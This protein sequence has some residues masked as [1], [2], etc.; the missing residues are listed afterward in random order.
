MQKHAAPV[1]VGTSL[2]HGKR[3]P[4]GIGYSMTQISDTCTR[5]VGRAYVG[6]V[7][8]AGKVQGGAITKNNCIGLVFDVNP[9]L[10]N[11]RVAVI[12]STFSKYVY[13]GMKFTYV[14]QCSTATSGSVALVFERDPLAIAANTQGTQFLSEV[15]SYEHAVLSPAY[16]QCSTAY[17]RDSK[18]LKTWFLGS[19]DATSSTRETS[20]G[21]LLVYASNVDEASSGLGF[22]V[23]DYVLDLVAPNLLPN[24]QNVTQI[25]AAP[26]QWRDLSIDAVRANTGMSGV[27]AKIMFDGVSPA[28][29]AEWLFPTTSL[30]NA[31]IFD[32]KH[33]VPGTVGEII[34]AGAPLP[35]DTSTVFACTPSNSGATAQYPWYSAKGDKVFLKQG[36][37]LYFV[38]HS[39][40]TD[41]AVNDNT[42]TYMSFHTTLNSAKGAAS[43]AMIPLPA[44]PTALL[45]PDALYSKANSYLALNGWSRL[46]CEGAGSEDNA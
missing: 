31:G 5:I 44:E 19:P 18:E 41:T 13:H 25:T 39:L 16:V 29:T 26:S 9:A 20:Q 34:V 35:N 4:G 10:L 43:T 1:S 28:A 6:E 21:Q 27:G 15:M 8:T 3:G 17:T 23:M 36:Q 33:L 14:P 38:V 42:T 30:I 22:V 45:L 24:K 46:I 32:A 40:L 2:A 11:D 7:S 12:A 37:K